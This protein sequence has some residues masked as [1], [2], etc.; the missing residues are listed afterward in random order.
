ME[1]I[2]VSAVI[3]G[4]IGLVIGILLG[5]AGKKFAVETDERETAVRE[6]L[7]GNNCCGCGY[8]GCDGLAAAIVKGSAPVDGC[9]VGGPPVAAAIGEIMGLKVEA[10]ERK[11]AFVRCG[12]SC[13]LAKKEYEYYG[14]EDCAM[15]IYVPNGGAKICNEGCLGFGTCVKACPFDAISIIDGLAVVDREK[16]KACGKCIKACPQHLIDLVPYDQKSLVK[17]K[18]SDKGKV[19][20][21]ECDAGCI[22]CMKCIKNCPEQAM[23]M[24]GNVVR[25]DFDKC[26]NCGS[27]VENCPRHC[28]VNVS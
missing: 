5:L 14:V 26:T 28:I 12:G 2:I 20:M 25:I 10:S 11:V 18:C 22:S 6:A 7:P 15:M 19:I 16:C 27:C 17:C 4:G 13:S 1:I 21:T 3:I 9:P 8:P 23:K 24:D